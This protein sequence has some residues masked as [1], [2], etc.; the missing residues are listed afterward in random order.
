[1]LSLD[2]VP[3]RRLLPLHEL[4]HR[5]ARD[6]RAQASVVVLPHVNRVLLIRHHRCWPL[7]LVDS[8][9]G[10]V[11]FSVFCSIIMC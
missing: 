3:Q 10:T 2:A 6:S 7:P 11:S 4:A 1:M 8:V 5:I 9:S